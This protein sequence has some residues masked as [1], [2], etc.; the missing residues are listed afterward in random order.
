M[1]GSNDQKVR[2][3]TDRLGEVNNNNEGVFERSNNGLDIK[4]SLVKMSNREG[5]TR[6]LS[7][8][9]NPEMSS[10]ELPLSEE[11][12]LD[13]YHT[14]FE[15]N[16][17]L[18][19]KSKTFS[20]K[21]TDEKIQLSR[22]VKA[23]SE[24]DGN[25]LNGKPM[26][27]HCDTS[28]ESSAIENLKSTML[29]S[30]EKNRNN[31]FRAATENFKAKLEEN[32]NKNPELKRADAV[33]NET[34]VDSM[35]KLSN[36]MKH[37]EKVAGISVQENSEKIKEVPNQQKHGGQQVKQKVSN[38][39]KQKTSESE[40]NR[41]G[42]YDL[43]SQSKTSTKIHLVGPDSS[44]FLS[45][46]RDEA[47]FDQKSVIKM[48]EQFDA[49]GVV[50]E[51]KTKHVS[52]STESSP[53]PKQALEMNKSPPVYE[54]WSENVEVCLC[55][56]D[57]Q[58]G[59]SESKV[60]VGVNYSQGIRQISPQNEAQR[61]KV[62]SYQNESKHAA[63]DS[64]FK[65]SDSLLMNDN[66]SPDE[67]VVAEKIH[68][69]NNDP[70]LK[71]KVSE[72]KEFFSSL[73]R[74]LDS[75]FV[76]RDWH[77][78]DRTPKPKHFEYFE[79]IE[80]DR[81]HRNLRGRTEAN[82]RKLDREDMPEDR[83]IEDSKRS[84]KHLY[85]VHSERSG[86][87]NHSYQKNHSFGNLNENGEHDYLQPNEHLY[88]ND[89]DWNVGHRFKDISGNV[90]TTGEENYI[91]KS[92]FTTRNLNGFNGDLSPVSD[93]PSDDKDS[94]GEYE[95]QPKFGRSEIQVPSESAIQKMIEDD[96]RNDY[97]LQKSTK[98]VRIDP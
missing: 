77:A 2:V 96:N 10:K 71:G 43:R 42:H 51:L 34:K 24:A 28:P 26:N 46:S 80:R 31:Q 61:I 87:Q 55:P 48:K 72:R 70:S 15:S 14:N 33:D 38:N 57:E 12:T 95:L 74:R 64:N 37:R 50:K 18:K 60:S 30:N 90:K 25:F 68:K 3:S 81:S 8:F 9:K 93:A 1:S 84:L 4:K 79:D 65:T 78:S 89:K 86:K 11:M 17:G 32:A 88:Q 63:I 45:N 23:K 22:L 49:V 56:K 29:E 47:G 85:A 91:Q 53:K 19:K 76:A 6:S 44:Q 16:T 54:Q 35:V 94:V 40:E 52:N 83:E 92:R 13:M 98:T 7:C 59:E 67:F 20:S 41:R 36:L 82:R 66:L 58:T 97:I 62:K 39:V 27:G 73:G 21:S 5:S 75:E 69:Y